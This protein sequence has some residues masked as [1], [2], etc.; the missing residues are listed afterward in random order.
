MEENTESTF[1][2]RIIDTI[3]WT[4]K[5]LFKACAIVFLV[6]IYV[7]LSLIIGKAL[8][9][10][11]GILIGIP[12]LLYCIILGPHII[13]QERIER[14]YLVHKW[15][16]DWLKRRGW[17]KDWYAILGLDHT[18]SIQEVRQAGSDI[19]ALCHPSINSCEGQTEV[20]AA[21]HEA[22]MAIRRLPVVVSPN[23]AEERLLP[24]VIHPQN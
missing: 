15:R 13:H 21:V 10:I 24:M 3:N 6:F 19:Y 17:D 5:A 20:M 2:E 8:I 7:F 16:L 9:W 22:R 11:F 4:I 1:A 18:A 14:K 12:V 23:L